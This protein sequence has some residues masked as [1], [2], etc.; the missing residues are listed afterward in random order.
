MAEARA[1]TGSSLRSHWPTSPSYRGII[2][3]VK[4][5]YVAKR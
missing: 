3:A 1:R 4:F 5:V 2:V